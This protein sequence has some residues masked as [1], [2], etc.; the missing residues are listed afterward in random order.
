[1]PETMILHP[2]L[3]AWQRQAAALSKSHLLLRSQYL[4]SRTEICPYAMLT[5]SASNFWL[6][7]K[8]HDPLIHIAC[9]AICSGWES[10]GILD[11]I[12]LCGLRLTT[13]RSRTCGKCQ[14]ADLGFTGAADDWDP[15]ISECL[16]TY[17][18]VNI[19]SCPPPLDDLSY[20]LRLK[21]RV[22]DIISAAYMQHN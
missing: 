1:M 14:C 22:H 17:A 20:S 19:E 16:V 5:A 8:A 11:R 18:T 12:L 3:V 13:G 7:N 15:R 4:A 10:L 9:P 2:V 21:I 6:N